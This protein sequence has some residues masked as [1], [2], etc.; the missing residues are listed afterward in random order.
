[1]PEEA[2]SFI[3]NDFGASIWLK[4]DFELIEDN[5]IDIDSI[6]EF[7]VAGCNVKFNDTFIPTESLINDMVLDKINQLIRLAKQHDREIKEL[8]EK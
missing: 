1:M 4:F 3:E 5:N 7:E 8:K 2:Q 6:E